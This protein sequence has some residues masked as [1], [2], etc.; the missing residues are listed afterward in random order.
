MSWGAL[1]RSA[2]STTTEASGPL[3]G[4]DGLWGIEGHAKLKQMRILFDKVK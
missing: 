4:T 2:H 3:V 1:C